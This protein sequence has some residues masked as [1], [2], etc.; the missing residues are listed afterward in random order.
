MDITPRLLPVLGAD[1][2][3]GGLHALRNFTTTSV[4]TVHEITEGPFLKEAN[5]NNT[6]KHLVI[7]LACFTDLDRFFII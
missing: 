4:R 2:K 7:Y 6:S 3:N 5:Q 1:Q